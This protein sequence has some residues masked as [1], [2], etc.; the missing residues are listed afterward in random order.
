MLNKII[1]VIMSF[2]MSLTGIFYTSINSVIDSA[3]EMMFGIPYTVQAV[4]SD[5]F[6]EI[7]DSDVVSVD[8]DSGFVDDLVAVF[9]DGDLGFFDKLSLFGTIGGTLIGWSAPIDLY[10]VRFSPMTYRQVV[11][12][13]KELEAKNGV[14]LAI[15][16]STYKTVLNGTPND[17]FNDDEELVW[18]E[19]NPAGSNWWLEAVQARQAWDYSDYFG[20]IDIG[21]VDAG[22]DLDHPEF[23]GRI[24]FP[25]GRQS[26]RNYEDIHGCHV[27][28]IIGANRNNNTGIAGLCDNSELICVDWTPELLQIWHTELAIFFGFSDVVKAGAKVV[29][30][31]LGTSG[32]RT[33]DSY[34][35]F[36]YTF[37]PAALSLMMA[38]LLSKGYDFVA[39]QSAGNGDFYTDALDASLNGHFSGINESNIFTGFYSISKSEILDRIIIVASADNDGNG[40]Y[41]Q[42]Y[43]SNVGP[44][45][46]LAAPGDNIYSCSVNGGYTYLSG[47]S[48][49]API[50]TGIAG[51]VWSVNP[52]FSGAQV[53][54]IVCSSTESIAK[55]NT[56]EDYYYDVDLYDYPMVNAKLAVEEAIRRTNVNSGT[57]SGNIVAADVAEIVFDGVS[58]TVFSDGSYS[59]VADEGSGIATV[60]DSQ[61]NEIG[62][63]ELNVIAGEETVVPDYSFNETLEETTTQVTSSETVL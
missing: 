15:P 26:D 30:F 37:S 21:I 9:I 17:V 49:S 4:K 39:V 24:S 16:V 34:N 41:T 31:S 29:N 6:D 52:S 46:D 44:V 53:A 13:C 60:L 14:S 63:M 18:D 28:G 57:V 7:S 38:S 11:A 32:S 1:S 59:F 36:D 50:V 56:E 58:H 2:A 42:S 43:Y 27:A 33:D 19:I 10:V 40:N 61:G 12:K 22:F 3:S 48:M 47:T 55:I 20:K 8:E 51:L 62:S 5:F 23:E 54:E 25:S 45:V 35:F